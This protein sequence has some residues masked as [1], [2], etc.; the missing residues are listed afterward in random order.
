MT[1]EADAETLLALVVRSRTEHTPSHRRHNPLPA[2]YRVGERQRGIY[3]IVPVR[4][5]SGVSC[6][7]V[8][9]RLRAWG[10]DW[11]ESR[12]RAAVTVLLERAVFRKGPRGIHA[13]PEPA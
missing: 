5:Q 1:P 9:A 13:P 2:A 11:P 6:L 7:D 3:P 12:V 10:V 8:S 4:P